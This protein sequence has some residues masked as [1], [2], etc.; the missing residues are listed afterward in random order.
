MA[1]RS[2]SVPPSGSEKR[3]ITACTHV[4]EILNPRQQK[5]SD[6]KCCFI[7]Y[8]CPLFVWTH[9]AFVDAKPSFTPGVKIHVELPDLNLPPEDEPLT[10]LSGNLLP[11]T[12]TWDASG[13]GSN[14]PNDQAEMTMK[15]KVDADVEL[16][17]MTG[18]VHGKTH[19]TSVKNENQIAPEDSASDQT[20]MHST[21]PTPKS[22]PIKHD[23]TNT[24][25]RKGIYADTELRTN[26]GLVHGKMH[27][28][29]VNNGNQI[30]LEGNTL[31][32]SQSRQMNIQP[33]ESLKLYASSD[34]KEDVV[35]PITNTEMQKLCNFRD[36]SFV[37]NNSVKK[38]NSDPQR[39][40]SKFKIEKL[41]S[42]L[43][44]LKTRRMVKRKMKLEQK[45]L[46][47]TPDTRKDFWVRTEYAEAFFKAYGK[48][49]Q[50]FA[51]PPAEII[52]PHERRL[53]IH[54]IILNIVDEKI[55]LE[56]YTVF[57][58]DIVN[59]LTLRLDARLLGFLQSQATLETR[60]Q[61]TTRIDI[62]QKITKSAVFLNLAYLKFFKENEN[63]KTTVQQIESFLNFMKDLWEDI[64]KGEN[65]TCNNNNFGDKLH[66]LLSFETSEH[67]SSPSSAMGIA[68]NIVEL[69]V[70]KAAN[71]QPHISLDYHPQMVEIINKII[72]YSNYDLFLS[73]I[74]AKD[75][76]GAI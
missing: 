28:P 15:R 59:H 50:R 4:S 9:Q 39:Q 14:L 43:N 71:F 52:T 70:Q 36:W 24:R 7:C 11:P 45:N 53:G 58:K 75:E 1:S 67:Q 29:S 55:V 37:K 38:I 68:W 17:T 69:W 33:I 23:S 54:N 6:M 20:E 44:E 13:E 12:S 27:K 22:F 40:E 46:G 30:T 21:K 18:L 47:Y 19:E 8:L 25:K 72:L 10:A 3:R 65:S 5:L 31:K 42:F 51:F 26:V 66:K 56:K 57:S 64:E 61:V 48:E 62:V 34:H 16:K 60:L 32:A 2:Q 76:I 63:G 35:G 73:K 41:L 74:P 49:R